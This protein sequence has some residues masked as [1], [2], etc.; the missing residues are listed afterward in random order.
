M[1]FSLSSNSP[2]T[3]VS[4]S[5]REIALLQPMGKPRQPRALTCLTLLCSEDLGVKGA[6]QHEERVRVRGGSSPETGSTGKPGLL[7][8]EA[9]GVWPEAL[10]VPS[11]KVCW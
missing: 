7:A 5:L 8:E 2:A 10:Q 6:E 3:G 1:D 4:L 9:L 11:P